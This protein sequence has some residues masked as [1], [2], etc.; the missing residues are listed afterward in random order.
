MKMTDPEFNE[1]VEMLGRK[2]LNLL[3]SEALSNNIKNLTN[4]SFLGSIHMK[5]TQIP[6]N[7]S[8]VDNLLKGELELK[9]NKSLK[10][11]MFNPI[12]KVLIIL[13]VVFNII[14]ITVFFLL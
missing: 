14:W 3:S 2:K 8:S 13:M 7:F 12:T 6:S 9:L 5:N 4:P 1:E 11:T 10:N